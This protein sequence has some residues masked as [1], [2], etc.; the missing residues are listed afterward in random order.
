LESSAYSLQTDL[1][2]ALSQLRVGMTGWRKYLSTAVYWNVEFS[3][4]RQRF[5]LRHGPLWFAITDEGCT[6]AVGKVG[7]AG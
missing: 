1:M 2:T 4:L 3:F 5:F 7:L 6:Q